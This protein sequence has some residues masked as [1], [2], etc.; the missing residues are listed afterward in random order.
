MVRRVVILFFLVALWP[1]FAWAQAKELMEAY[2]Q[3]KALNA[4][5]RYAAAEPFARQA[6]SLGEEVF[7]PEH[8]STAVLLNDLGLLYHA[9]SRFPE[10]EPVFERALAIR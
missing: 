2:N 9:Q 3:Y 6:L 10:A 8:A 5:G 4:Q 7:G 1:G